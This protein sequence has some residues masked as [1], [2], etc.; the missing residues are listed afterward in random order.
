MSGRIRHFGP[1]T[2]AA[3]G[4]TP[5]VI[6]TN[7]RLAEFL[8]VLRAAKWVAVDTEADSLHAY[9][10]KVCLIQISTAA[11]DRLVDPLADLD[12][13]RLLDGLKNHDLI[14]HGADYDLRLLWKHHRF[15]PR[16]VFDTMLAAR[17]LGER[18][19]S[20][21]A[22]V[23]KHLGVTLDK[24]MQKADWARRPLTARMETYARNDTCH[25]KPLADELRR[26]LQHKHRLAW[27][28]ESCARQM[29]D[30]ACDPEPDSNTVW[31]MK[32]SHLLS[33]PALAVLRELWHW[34][35]QEALTAKRPPFFVT[36][37]ETL[38]RLADA[39]ANSRPIDALLPRRFSDRRRESLR[40]AIARGLALPA[41][42]HPE[43]LRF[44]SSRLTEAERRRL[45]D[46]ERRRDAQAAKLDLD[47]ALIA[48][49]AALLGLARNWD[50]HAPELM[51]WQRE[52]L[53]A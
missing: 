25:L 28:E 29:K 9:P 34:R 44:T 43:I 1:D 20:L 46:L 16:S 37:H 45:G 35:E 3:A 42:Q 6:D 30:C 4:H 13:P 50:K 36:A 17:L 41:A 31:R 32:G 51:N 14:M 33:R 19:F 15:T 5:G 48:P 23:A 10:E 40:H 52:L 11:G 2:Q 38:T 21:N 27:H 26:E 39:A 18:Q 24:G 47:P 22:L 8:P 53:Q 7:E 49:R 12:L